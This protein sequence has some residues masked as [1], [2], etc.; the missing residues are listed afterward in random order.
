MEKK[1]ESQGTE[2]ASEAGEMKHQAVMAMDHATWKELIS[3]FKIKEPIILH[4]EEEDHS[5]VGAKGWYA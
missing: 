4:R 3:V 1:K 2:T 5:T